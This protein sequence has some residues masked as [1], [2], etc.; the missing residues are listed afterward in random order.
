MRGK[1]RGEIG[2]EAGEV[3]GVVANAPNTDRSGEKV[4]NV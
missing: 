2:S 3:T 1:G 4:W